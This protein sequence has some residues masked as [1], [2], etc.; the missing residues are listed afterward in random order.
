MKTTIVQL[1]SEGY[2]YPEGHPLSDGTVEIRYMTASDEDILTDQNL[3]RKGE[4]LDRLIES[5]LVNERVNL[6]DMLVGDK[7]AIILG[8]RI[9]AYGPQYAYEV[10]CP[11]CNEIGRAHV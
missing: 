2:F 3:L 6:D 11:R 7:G 9:G 8:T 5:V 10:D 1:P 4:A